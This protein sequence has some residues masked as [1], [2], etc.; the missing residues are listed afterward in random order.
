MILEISNTGIDIK[1]SRQHGTDQ[2]A[3]MNSVVLLLINGFK[4]YR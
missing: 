1:L 4:R 3:Q 2:T